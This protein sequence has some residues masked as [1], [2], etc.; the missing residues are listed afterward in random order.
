MCGRGAGCGTIRAEFTTRRTERTRVVSGVITTGTLVA[1]AGLQAAECT[2]VVIQ[3][4][5]LR[6]HQSMNIEGGCLEV[7]NGV[8]SATALQTKILTIVER[9]AFMFGGDQRGLQRW[10]V[11]V[12]ETGGHDEDRC[13]V[14]RAIN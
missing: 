13:G 10:I 1:H 2:I 14:L 8:A 3:I 6:I 9:T 7:P 5:E 12:V 4:A 11:S